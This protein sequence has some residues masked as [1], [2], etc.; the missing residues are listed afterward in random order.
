[1]SHFYNTFL[2]QCD[3]IKLIKSP[4]YERQDKSM[5]KEFFECP[6]VFSGH[7]FYG[8]DWLESL[9]AIPSPLALVTSYKANGK[10]NG[11]MQSWFSFSSEDG[12]YCIFSS[13]HKSSHMYK[14]VQTTKQL[15]INFM[16]AESYAK[17][18][19][20]IKNNSF[21]EDELK[22]SGLTVF[23]ARK[24][25][26]PLVEECFLNLECE[27]VWEKELFPNSDHVVMCVKTVNAWFDSDI[28]TDKNG[29]RYSE[30]GYLYNIHSP[31]DPDSG[32]LSETS[33]GIIQKFRSYSEMGI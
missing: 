31:A 16:S 1:M 20:T 9:T 12:F 27:Y 11:S 18:Y 8:F 5:K 3:I 29:G 19:S 32:V 33:V 7:N 10:A 30:S 23:P 15:A 28:Y 14:T 2:C 4:D 21:D 13:V 17:C 22:A 26:A 6:E 24:V 25:N